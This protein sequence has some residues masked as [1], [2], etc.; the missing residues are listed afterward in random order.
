MSK[1]K[2]TPTSVP[3]DGIQRTL[4]V[5]QSYKLLGI[6]R[7]HF[8]NLR[9][10]HNLERLPKSTLKRPRYRLEDIKRIGVLEGYLQDQPEQ[11]AVAPAEPVKAEAPPID[12]KKVRAIDAGFKVMPGFENITVEEW[13]EANRDAVRRKQSAHL[14]DLE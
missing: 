10:K 7:T 14:P 13:H 9:N 1:D 4:N 6:E 5:T 12:P 2:R 3:H 11:S 8:F